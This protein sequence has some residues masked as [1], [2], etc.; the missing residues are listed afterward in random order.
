M[1]KNRKKSILF[2]IPEYSQGGVQ[3][4]LENLLSF[5]KEKYDINI[6]CLYEDGGDYYKEIFKPFIIKKSRLYYCLH[7]NVI[8]RKFLGLYMKLNKSANWIWLYKREARI[9]EKKKRYDTIIAFQEY[10]STLVGTLFEKKKDIQFITWLHLDYA[11]IE[12]CG[13]ADQRKL[14]SFYDRVVCVSATARSSFLKVMN[15]W[16]KDVNYIYNAIDTNKINLQASKPCVDETFIVDNSFIIISVGRFAEIK[17]FDI[18]PKI[19]HYIKKNTNRKFCWYILAAGDL[20]RKKTES[21]I[22]R[23]NVKDCVKI[24]EEKD[25]P[26]PYIANSNLLVCTSRSESYSY[27]I[28]EAKILHIPVVCNDF[29]VAY[30]VI[31]KELG[32]VTNIDNMH[33]IIADIIENKNDIY[34]KAKCR[35][36]AYTYNNQKIVEQFTDLIDNK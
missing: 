9:I 16:E 2:I 4:S 26:Y 21:E 18:I 3:K 7:D 36:K 11:I 12:N 5:I 24:L 1:L 29:P 15:P 6:L 30:E 27:V 23:F 33:S 13:S 8:T 17:Q 35:A 10:T 20:Y 31:P 34:S 28:A 14:Y 22:L 19:A 25:N 32:W